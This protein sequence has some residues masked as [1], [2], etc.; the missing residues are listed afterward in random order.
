MKSAPEKWK[1]NIRS[2]A[3]LGRFLCLVPLKCEVDQFPQDPGYNDNHK[4][5]VYLLQPLFPIGIQER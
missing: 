1:Y 3:S 5:E 2:I 4:R